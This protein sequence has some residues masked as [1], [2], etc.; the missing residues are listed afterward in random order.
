ME[1]LRIIVADDHPI[2]RDGVV[3]TLREAGS[4]EVVDALAD[5]PCAVA[6]AI[7]HAPDAILLDVS[8]PGGGLSAAAEIAARCP[9]V[10]IIILT[11]A[12]DEETVHQALA[13]GAAAYVLKGVSGSELVDIVRRVVA[14]DAYITPSLA[15]ALLKP[16]SATR[17]TD[18][19]LLNGLTAREQDILSALSKGASN[20]EIA[21]ELHMGERTVKHHMTNI[22]SKLHL[23]NRVEAA[24]FA[25][26]NLDAKESANNP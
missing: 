16:H 11:S 17:G 25:H 18:E 24:L 22:L 13:K 15:A 2:Y 10:R 26:K 23:K 20:K 8:M 1:T 12:E 21:A 14:G 5:A 6:S 4:I 9:A 3:R 19:G 7:E